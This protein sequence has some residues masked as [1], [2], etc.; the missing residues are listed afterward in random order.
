VIDPGTT[1]RSSAERVR[2][3]VASG[4]SRRQR[5]E[6]EQVFWR[7]APIAAI[8]AAA[9]VGASRWLDAPRLMSFVLV[10]AV[11][12]GLAAY[13]RTL[14]RPRAIDDATAARLDADAGL[15]GELRSAHWFATRADADDWTLLHLARAADRLASL[16]WTLSYPA[17]RPTAARI[18]TAAGVVLALVLAVGA[19]ARRASRVIAAPV[20]AAS[21]AADQ[22]PFQFQ[23][24]PPDVLEQLEELLANAEKGA[25]ATKKETDKALS[26]WHMF[27]ALNSDIDPEKL[28]ELANA[29]DPSKKGS[30]K[31]AADKL[32]DLAERSLKASDI[33]DLPADL[34]QALQD[35]GT[36]L[37]QSADAEQRAAAQAAQNASDSKAGNDAQ[38]NAAASDGPPTL[39]SASI[40]MSKD[41]NAGAGAGMMMMSPQMGPNGNPGGGF[42]GAGNSGPPPNSGRMKDLTQAL[43]KE[44]IEATADTAGDNLL[45][46]TRRKTERGQA[47]VGFTQTM[48]APSAR[49]HAS[50]PPPVPEDRRGAV[51]SYF[52]RTP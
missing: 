17:L 20:A 22:E 1:H 8:A 47:T 41:V 40:Q 43:R 34:R 9:A 6:V 21:D 5:R 14:S 31:A 29:M 30:V 49:S 3:A 48:A 32:T 38:A 25:K 7:V 15:G 18:V 37:M 13:R 27:T 39:D 45:S 24:L 28:K 33:N 44:T 52:S 42:G 46:E 16:D 2:D 51:Q 19:P 12:A 23:M 50:A 35:L 10:G 4:A 26:L 11:L 36:Q